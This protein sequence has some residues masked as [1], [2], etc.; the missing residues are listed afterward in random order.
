MLR[1]KFTFAVLSVQ[2]MMA[3]NLVGYGLGQD[4]VSATL[5][6]VFGSPATVV[7]MLCTFF[8]AAHLMFEHR[9]VTGTA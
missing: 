5:G 1:A 4:G 8:C 7:C 9:R 3:A 2:V 6:R